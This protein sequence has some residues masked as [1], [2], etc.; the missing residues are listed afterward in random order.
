MK[1][2]TIA[3]NIAGWAVFAVA[4]V[5]YLLTI[6]PTASFWDCGEFISCAYK[7]DV[8]HPP[9][10]PFFMIFGRVATLF[11]SDPAHVAM[12]VNA[13]SATFSA[14]TILFLFWTIT[15]LA[16]KIVVKKDGE[17][18]LAQLIGILGAGAVGA[19]AY[20]WSDTFWFSAV[21]GEVYA[22]SSLFTAVV[23][24][25]ILKWED[26]A[27]EPHSDR[28][29]IFIA[30]LTGLSIGVHLLNLLT[31]PAIV[32]VYYFKKFNTTPK[33]VILALLASFAIVGVMMFGFI[34]GSIEMAGWFDLFFVNTLGFSYNS[35]ALIYVA[36]TLAILVWAIFESYKAVSYIRMSLSFALSIII[37][38]IPFIG[39]GYL[40][41]IVIIGGLIFFLIKNKINQRWAN[42]IVIA[43]TV[44][45]IGYVSYT[46][47]IIRSMAKPP[48]DQNSP[49]NVFALKSYI[50]REQY[51][52]T[53]LIYGQYYNSELKWEP[54]GQ[55]C[56]P[57][58]DEGE[59]IW[60]K[61]TAESGKDRYINTGKRTSYVYAPEL[62]T[63]FPR[64][65]SSQP[66]H[67]AGYKMWANIE[68]TNVPYDKCGRQMVINKPTFGENLQYFFKYQ[69]GFMYWR[70]FMWNFAGRQN[71]I[72][73]HGEVQNGNW[74]S[75]INFI[76]NAL[77][78]D[79]T[80]LP[81]DME[82]NKGHN[83]YYLLPL[84]LGIVG[85]FYQLC[86]GKQGK[87][88]FW[89][90][91]LLFFMTGIAIVLYLNQ[92][93]YQP[94]ER[95][96]AYAGSF[97]AFAIW[98]GFGVLGIIKLL[99]KAKVNKTVAAAVA[100]VAALGVPALMLSE[101][102][103]DHDRS[104][105]RACA[106]FGYNY[107]ITCAPNAV[108]FTMGDNDTFPLWYAQ[109][110]EGIRTDVRVCNLSYLQTDWYIDQMKRQYYES[111]AL[112]IN[113][114]RDKY[115]D[116]TR[117][118]GA[119]N[120][121]GSPINEALVDKPI[122]LGQALDFYNS[123]DPRAKDRS[124]DNYMPSQNLYLTIDTAQIIKT[125]SVKPSE[126]GNIAPVVP[127]KLGNRIIKNEYAILE[128]LNGNNWERPVYY[129]I[130]VGD[131]ANLGLRGYSR[132]EGLAR[133]I[134]PVRQ[135]SGNEID[136]DLMYEN[137]VH[138]FRW[139][140][141]ENPR[142]YLDPTNMSMYNTSRMLFGQLAEKLLREGKKDKAL[143]TLDYAMKVIPRNTVPSSIYMISYADLYYQLGEK[144][145]A[146]DVITELME[147][148]D[149]TL[150]WFFN[151]NRD[152]AVSALD[153]QSNNDI[154]SNLGTYQQGLSILEKHDKTLFEKYE[155]NF[156][157]YYRQ[158]NLL[159][160]TGGFSE[161]Y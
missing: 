134:L 23:V 51:G 16:R 37:L 155:K 96:Y 85:I 58:S 54:R 130:T 29:L 97:Y 95:D 157:N 55:Y 137:M 1:K 138:K 61:D 151:L 81:P 69:V 114:S 133:R 115:A 98:I 8:G 132:N 31:I 19:L 104:V 46:V 72:Q 34:P 64:M 49:D 103:D 76:D 35:G 13:L 6:E 27:D 141:V 125:Q 33:G 22:F 25:A 116:N 113:I 53:P 87:Q 47:T 119:V 147:K 142:I 86:G 50:N 107:L 39:N 7:L 82:N 127:I 10:A 123:N 124:G 45:F 43:L 102:F 94:R 65:Y 67:I 20:T 83:K 161:N 40:L 80:N 144:A 120:T 30:Y 63:I 91:F 68:G 3:N 41:P 108:I 156:E 42:L 66:N 105:R 111:E 59:T 89:V 93:P 90:T 5:T 106:D 150:T 145:K 152:Q 56:V 160:N 139:G 128:L 24:W 110:V 143:E 109:E 57:A 154:R 73:G 44:I 52:E 36:L 101:N 28:W 140:N 38:G 21:E 15:H 17:M 32:L 135:N 14:L 79:Q 74:I 12:M 84:L 18:S 158:Y 122:E 118:V 4:L 26:V 9:G 60:I 100:T 131:E 153:T 77:V 78:G 99:E 48:M 88:S 129:A 159:R 149:K 92:P 117:T 70:Y 11:A 136:A 62:C 121:A 148:T 2:F 126:Y 71:D 112:P 146:E 75:G